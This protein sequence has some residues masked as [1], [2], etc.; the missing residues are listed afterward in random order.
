M[1]R[2]N[3]RRAD[4]KLRIT[5]RLI[6]NAFNLTVG[7]CNISCLNITIILILFLLLSAVLFTEG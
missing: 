5:E 1:T 2:I 6:W 7:I 4:A 3:D